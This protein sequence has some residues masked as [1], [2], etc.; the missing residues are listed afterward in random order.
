[1]YCQDL[2]A[3]GLSLAQPELNRNLLQQFLEYFEQ[4]VLYEH[5]SGHVEQEDEGLVVLDQLDDVFGVELVKNLGPE[6]LLD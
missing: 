5:F 3:L 4:V 1:L 6:L 2:E